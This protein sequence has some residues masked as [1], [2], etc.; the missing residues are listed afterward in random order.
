MPGYG[1]SLAVFIGCQP[2]LLGF[3]C[4]LFQFADKFLLV[5]WNF[6]FW[7]ESV[8]VDTQFSFLQVPDMAIARHHLEVA[9]QEFLN[10]LRLCGR[11]Y[12]NEIFLHILSRLIHF[13]LQKYRKK[14]LTPYIYREFFNLL[15]V[16][17][18]EG[19][20]SLTNGA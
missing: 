3:L 6:I 16:L 19:V 2:N 12:Y 4:I 9:T 5:F 17:Q 20:H 10:R 8:I 13:G 11:L 1:F 14:S 15:T 7:N 18:Q